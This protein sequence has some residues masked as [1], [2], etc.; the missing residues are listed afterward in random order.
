MSPSEI[1]FHHRMEEDSEAAAAILAIAYLGK[2][3]PIRTLRTYLTREDLAGHPCHS[4]PWTHLRNVGNDRAFI[5]TMGVDV[6]TF[7]SLLVPFELIWSS[8]TI[9]RSDVNP[10]GAPQFARRSLDAAGGLALL[11]HWMSSTMAGCSLQQIFS[12]TPAVCVRDLQYARECLLSVLRSLQISRISWP[13]TA[14]KCQCYSSLIESRFPLLTKCFG[15][16]DG[17]NLPVNVAEDEK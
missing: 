16:I 12:I 7:E 2:R 17:L 1:G 9:P 5:T 10:N 8:S 4:S 11:L 3:S 13:S 15:F 6:Q 14:A